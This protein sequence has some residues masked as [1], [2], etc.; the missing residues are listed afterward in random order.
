MTTRGNRDRLSAHRALLYAAALP[1][2]GEWIAGARLQGVLTC[3]FFL[4]FLAWFCRLSWLI[5]EPLLDLRGVS[6]EPVQL[7]GISLL[8]MLAAWF[9]GIFNA[10]RCMRAARITHGLPPQDSIAWGALISWLCP[11]AGQAYAGKT[12]FGLL[13]ILLN[14]CGLTLMGPVY[15][16]L[17]RGIGAL[18]EDPNLAAQPLTVA[19]KLHS[20]FFIMESSVPAVLLM[21]VKMLAIADAVLLLA[22]QRAQQRAQ[23]CDSME[24]VFENDTKV[25][26]YGTT[27][28]K[29]GGL[30][31][32]G[33]F[34]PGAGQLLTGRNWGRLALALFLSI[35]IIISILLHQQ[36]LT[37]TQASSLQSFCLVIRIVVM[38][39]APIRL[40]SAGRLQGKTPDV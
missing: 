22:Q 31:I 26:W 16:E 15:A 40:L 6:L 17:G 24:Y 5:V 32:L 30:F 36:L 21:C 2:L 13:L 20:L 7:L 1:G 3:G 4:G 28:A 29:A 11:G 27:E 12:V 38:F 14:L 39:E 34:A 19:H 23:Q 37:I 35:H 9:W 33:W 18:L 25:P 10:V 8:C